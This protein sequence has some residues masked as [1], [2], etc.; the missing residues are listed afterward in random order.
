VSKTRKPSSSVSTQP[1]PIIHTLFCFTSI[2]ISLTIFSL[3]SINQSINRFQRI[4][5]SSATA[6]PQLISFYFIYFLYNNNI[7]NIIIT[8]KI[9]V[10]DDVWWWIEFEDEI[11]IIHSLINLVIWCL[12]PFFSASRRRKM[13]PQRRRNNNFYQRFRLMIP[14]IS[15][16]AA[17]LL[18]LFAV[19]SFLAPSP[20][21]SDD[22]IHRRRQYTTV[23]SLTLSTFTLYD[24]WS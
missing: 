13:A 20:I 21:E 1:L 7:I 14:M 17:V 12:L 4:T 24:N 10:Y 22:H 6:Q 18:F 9:L 15:A 3:T 5:H 23:I 19:L 11:I 8:I 2:S 16:V